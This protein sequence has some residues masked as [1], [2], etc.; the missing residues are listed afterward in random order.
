MRVKNT[1]FAT[2]SVAAAVRGAL[3]VMAFAPAAHAADADDPVLDLTVPASKVEIGVGNVSNGSFKFGEYNGL[4]KKGAYAIG[5]FD[6][7][8]G[9]YGSETDP[10]RWRITGTDLGLDTRDVS[11]EYSE[12]G[13]FKINLGYDELLRNRSDTFQTP[14]LG[15]GSNAFTLPSTWIV[16]R[17]PQVSATA[18]NFR[19]LSPVTGLANSI[20][21]GVSTPPTAAQIATVNSIIAADVPLF[22]NVDLHT[23]RERYDGGVSYNV[24]PQWEVKASISH[25]DK[26]GYKPMNFLST[27]VGTSAV[28]LPDPIDQSHDQYNASVNYTGP[29]GFFQAAYYGSIFKNNVNS[30]TWQNPFDLTKTSTFSSPPDNQFHQI[31]MTG[32]YKFSSVTKLVVNGAYGRSTQNESFVVGP[33]TP[34][35]LPA[36]SLNGLV[37]TKAF[38]IKL[39]SRPWK[40]LNVSAAYKFDDRDNR[41]AVN[42]YRFYDAG[43]PPSGA[44]PFNAA[45]GLPAGTMGSNINIYAN[46]PYS[47]KSNQFN[48]DADYMLVKGQWLKFGY[49]YQKIERDCQGSWINCVDAPEAKEN[50]GRVEWRMN[51]IENVSARLGYVYSQRRVNYDENGWLAL[52]PM[53]NVV[54]TGAT[55][56]VV[57]F[58]RQ[59]GL[60]GFG[61]IAPFVP[62]QPGN[63]GVFFPN[64]ASLLQQFY[65]SRNDIHELVGMRRFFLADRNRDKVR[66]AIDWQ[67]TDQLSLT[68]GVDYNN[69]D[70][71]NSV[72]GLQS[73]KSWNANF[74]GG[75]AMSESISANAFYSYEDQRSRSAGAS[76]SSG[77]ITNTATVGGVAGNTV[78]SGG[79][80]ATVT[81]RNQNAKIDPCLN[82]ST[83]MRDKV[84]T[85]G[86]GLK[87]KGLIGGRLNVGADLVFT[88]SRT[89]IGVKGGTYSNNPAAVA[90]RP[91]VNPAVL[92][93]PAADMPEV[94]TQTTELRFNAQYVIDRVST[95]RFLYWYQ[96]L[97]SNDYVYD[98]MQFGA[99]ITSVIPTNEQAPN[100]SVNVFGVSY[101][102]TFR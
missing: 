82:W 19:G 98:A 89:N 9:A 38:N 49:E 90:G 54:P 83:D 51:M 86:I 11:A 14:Y 61:P 25:E 78:V 46:R 32:G 2:R 71:S 101:T 64:N 65:G 80:F 10:T 15:V 66:S 29:K 99:G 4:E 84:N 22:Q 23:K 72:F 88:K 21:G 77:A 68:A 70:Y 35:G 53:A 81:D 17:V 30:V 24:T 95:V 59:S 60:T 1:R 31:L 33:E 6:L 12:Q 5:N 67:A 91:A 48:A 3:V 52:V 57:D 62:L 27:A 8:G 102:R 93:I 76:Y 73:A 7:R 94:S 20:V 87:H 69:D 75:Y 39:T 43:E 44:S 40:D 97:K 50:T 47:K 36:S 100:Y 45:F 79:C 92:F 96:R 18:G 37:I 55:Q 63:L 42:T 56:S 74:E 58:L 26:T 85:A 13:R 34:F 16:P 41:T 28:T